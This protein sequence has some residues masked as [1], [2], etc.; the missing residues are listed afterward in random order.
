ME[1]ATL[2]EQLVNKYSWATPDDRC[3]RILKH[4]SPIVE[5]GCGANAYWSQCM[6]NAGIDVVAY[7]VNPQSG[8]TIRNGKKTRRRNAM[9]NHN[10]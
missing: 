4:Y 9:H 1:Q 2:G 8:G 7:D 10:G 3:M 6:A 5:I